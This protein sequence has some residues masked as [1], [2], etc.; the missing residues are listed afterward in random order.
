MNRKPKS[1]IKRNNPQ[2]LIEALFFQRICDEFVLV[3]H[4]NS[5]HRQHLLHERGQLQ[6][7]K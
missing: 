3:T 1:K 4:L 6:Q 7:K 2:S 5:Q